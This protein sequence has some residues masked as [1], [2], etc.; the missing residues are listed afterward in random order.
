MW[1]G[2]NNPIKTSD[3]ETQ[4]QWTKKPQNKGLRNPKTG[5]RNPKTM[6]KETQKQ[7]T[8]KP[9][10]GTKKPKNKG[11]INPEYLPCYNKNP[12]FGVT[13]AINHLSTFTSDVYNF[14]LFL[15]EY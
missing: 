9:Q 8:K 10:N 6:D 1:R 11:Q 4:K 15:F 14:I 2:S 5:Q 13:R 7:G 12:T 3:K